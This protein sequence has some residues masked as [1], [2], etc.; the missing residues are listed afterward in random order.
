MNDGRR[1]AEAWGI[2]RVVALVAAA[3]AI[4]LLAGCTGS[5][6][7]R[8]PVVLFVGGNAGAGASDATLI[9]FRTGLPRATPDDEVLVPLPAFGRTLPGTLIDLATVTEDRPALFALY[10]DDLGDHRL[11]FFD[12]ERLDP[13]DPASLS[14]GPDEDLD[15][16]AAVAASRVLGDEA[17]CATG[18]TASSQGS[19]IGV[20][21]QPAICGRAG[22]AAIV[23][24]ERASAGTDAPRVE[25]TSPGTQDAP[26]IPT[27]QGRGDDERLIWLSDTGGLVT[28][29]PADPD[30]A[31]AAAV[32]VPLDANPTSV[33]RAGTGVAVAAGRDLAFVRPDT[34]DSGPVWTLDGIGTIDDLVAADALPGVATIAIGSSGLAVVAGLEDEP[35]ED[36]VDVVIDASISSASVGPYGYLFVTS[37]AGVITYDALTATT[38]GALTRV[39]GGDADLAGFVPVRSGWAFAAA[40]VAP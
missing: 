13:D 31:P 28:W 26:A 20:L 1:A 24:I 2:S 33:G 11:A 5:Q 6:E 10:R 36:R 12:T 8:T 22:A 9:A 18:M 23:A 39:P 25:P 40:V 19:W 17:L 3:L 32:P 30:E 14:S 34:G 35:S 27:F 4:G 16:T 38:G 29:R 15:L 7:T 37:D 21:H